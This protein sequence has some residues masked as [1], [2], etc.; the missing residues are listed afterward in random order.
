MNIKDVGGNEHDIFFE[1]DVLRTWWTDP[2]YWGLSKEEAWKL[3]EYIREQ[4]LK[5]DFSI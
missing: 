5:D 2:F 4:C 1:D 3:S